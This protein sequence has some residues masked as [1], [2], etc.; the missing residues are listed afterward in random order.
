MASGMFPTTLEWLAKVNSYKK[1][2]FWRNCN[3]NNFTHLYFLEVKWF[4]E[5]FETNTYFQLEINF[6]I[7][8]VVNITANTKFVSALSKAV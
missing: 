8:L 6:N 5:N 3:F 4:K 1:E 7:H 2:I